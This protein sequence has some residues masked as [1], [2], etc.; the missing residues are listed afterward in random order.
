MFEICND[1]ILA[2]RCRWGPSTPTGAISALTRV[3]NALC[4]RTS[5]SLGPHFRG[6]NGECCSVRT[7]LFS[8]QTGGVLGRFKDAKEN[9]PLFAALGQGVALISCLFASPKT[10]GVGAPTRR[11]ARITPGGVSGLLRTLGA[12]AV[13]PTPLGAPTRHLGLYAFDRGRTGPA[14]SGRRGCPST[15]RGRRLRLPPARRCRSRSPPSERLMSAP[16]VEWIGM[17][18]T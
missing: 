4:T 18:K 7:H 10:K 5:P 14:P 8:C 2:Q 12:L 16:L 9:R 15:A 17:A 6:A 3:F 11:I 1:L 13:H